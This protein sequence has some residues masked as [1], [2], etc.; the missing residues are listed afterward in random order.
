[1]KPNK[2]ADEGYV[3]VVEIE[4][5]AVRPEHSGFVLQG[6]GADRSEYRLEM[7]LDIPFDRRTQTILGEML[8]QSEWRVLRKAPNPLRRAGPRAG[9]KPVA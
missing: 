1:M 9:R 4:V 2:K 7:H 5:D 8:A 3:A 6:R